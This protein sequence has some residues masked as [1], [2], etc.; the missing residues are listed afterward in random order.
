MFWPSVPTRRAD[1]YN[2]IIRLIVESDANAPIPI[3]VGFT[4]APDTAALVPEPGGDPTLVTYTGE[5]DM[6]LGS[7]SSPILVVAAPGV[8][9]TPE[10]GKTLQL[11]V[12][13]SFVTLRKTGANAWSLAGDLAAAA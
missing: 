9:I 8:T 13:F 7:R 2:P 1:G 4:F 10:A 3:G 6:F 12:P 11:Q 5:I